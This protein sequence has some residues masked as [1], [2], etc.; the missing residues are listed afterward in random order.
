MKTKE[1]EK[2][3]KYLNLTKNWKTTKYEDD[4]DSNCNWCS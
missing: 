4:G 1:K 3:D 2:R